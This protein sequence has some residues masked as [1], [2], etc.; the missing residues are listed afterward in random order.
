MRRAFFTNVS[1]QLTTILSGLIFFPFYFELL[2][3]ETYY[4]ITI[5]IAVQAWFAILDFGMSPAIARIASLQ[6]NGVVS[7][8]ALILLIR[9]CLCIIFTTALTFL[10][11][12][13]ILKVGN[14]PKIPLDLTVQIYLSATFALILRWLLNYGKF[15][16]NGLNSQA[17]ANLILIILEFFKHLATIL[18]LQFFSND[19]IIYFV[20]LVMF[21]LLQTISVYIIL[22]FK[23]P[24]YR[25]SRE[26]NP[27]LIRDYFKLVLTLGAIAVLGVLASQTDKA[28]L[29]SFLT[30]E[31]LSYFAVILMYL[32]GLNA[33]QAPIYQTL[34]PKIT[35]HSSEKFTIEK[36]KLY[37]TF[38]GLMVFF[39][40]FIVFFVAEY[41]DIVIFWWTGNTLLTT[42]VS[43]NIIWFGLIGL[44]QN[45]GSFAFFLQSA[46][47]KY[48]YHFHG[49]IM[50]LMIQIGII[51]ILSIEH[52]FDQIVRVLAIYRCF[53]V[54]F[55][56]RFVHIK[57]DTDF[58]V[59]WFLPLGML[60]ITNV[61]IVSGISWI[62]ADRTI[63]IYLTLMVYI[64]FILY[65]GVRYVR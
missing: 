54:L 41:S 64:P 10:V 59:L 23:V 7:I 57:L 18:L 28:L 4:L 62:I 11:I 2:G 25:S 24:F 45:L 15:I 40:S 39:T 21:T 58:S 12:S 49:S 65:L 20:M 22:S 42:W 16:L 17:F 50:N 29:M 1:L 3:S 44:A 8:S 51:W 63:A 48:K 27:Q 5:F 14:A 43:Q 34:I 56:T 46:V 9:I 47:G 19:I 55:W 36:K 26:K 35:Q 61:L 60:V 33:M 38:A 32:N 53:W 37:S 6:V 31:E 13:Y 52:N 30:P